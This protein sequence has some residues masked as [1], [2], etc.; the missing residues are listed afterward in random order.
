MVP[1][2][3]SANE[4]SRIE[5]L[6]WSR[7]DVLDWFRIA[8]A[9]LKLQGVLRIQNAGGNLLQLGGNRGIKICQ[10]RSA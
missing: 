5:V 1:W 7:I 3:N 9:E 10:L 8:T 4:L 2:P 6:D